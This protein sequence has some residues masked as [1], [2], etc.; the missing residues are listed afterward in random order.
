MQQSGILRCSLLIALG[1]IGIWATEDV[2]DIR[3]DAGS[4]PQR[5]A[6][7]PRGEEPFLWNNFEHIVVEK[8]SSVGKL[9]V[10]RIPDPTRRS[11]KEQAA[12]AL[13]TPQPTAQPQKRQDN[14]QVQALSQQLQSLSQ[15]AT[16]ALSS[17][18]SS[19]SSAMS[20][21]S[22]SAQSVRQSADQA[23]RSANQN[24][25]DANRQL[26]QTIS[27]ASSALSAASARASDDLGR[28]LSS[29]SS[30]LSSNLAS[31]QSSANSAISAARV[32]ASSSA[33]NA[34]NIAASQ[35]Q[36]ARADASGIRGDANSIVTQVQSNSVSGTNVAVIVTVSV[37]GTAILTAIASYFVVRCLRKKRRNRDP[38]AG[39]MN[40]NNEKQQYDTS[41]EKPIAVRG[42]VASPS[43]RFTPFGGGTGYPMDKFKLPELG[44]SPFLRKKTNEASPSLS[45]IGF[46]RS[47]Y[48]P[49][50]SSRD[51]VAGPSNSSNSDVYGV[52]PTSFRLQKENSIKSATSVRLIRVGSNKGKAQEEDETALLSPMNSPPPPLPAQVLAAP[53]PTRVPVAVAVPV[54]MQAQS[55]QQ[56]AEPPSPVESQVAEPPP[57]TI[58]VVRNSEPPEDPVPDPAPI[59]R[60]ET[61]NVMST[62]TSQQRL[63]FRDSSDVESAEPSPASGAWRRSRSATMSSMRNT[64]TAFLRTNS[65]S[66]D[67]VGS[68]SP[69][70]RPKNA[71]P[72]SFATFP[73]IRDGPPRG[74][75]AEAIMNR[76]RSGLSGVTAR[77]RDEAERRKREL[78]EVDGGRSSV[79]MSKD[80][81]EPE[82]RETRGP[83]WP[84]GST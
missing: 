81:S 51:V 16:Q 53:A 57:A 30:R 41:Y 60:S 15:S 21:V 13:T 17:V 67:S 75:A 50:D 70:R 6:Q 28:S 56:F 24:A 35:I 47:N 48:S 38:L 62:M 68:Q 2:G 82:K 80:V 29:M 39:G 63:R 18:S 54:T 71:G 74:S 33:S 22:Q 61:M 26:S 65:T 64:N 84:F 77:L 27:S 55:Q 23:V 37:V 5:V 72:A 69:P 12:P 10:E 34:I 36:A 4:S 52:S 79:R 45:D 1:T 58:R 78:D 42:T 49:R 46:A 14:G 19:A 25:D 7:V 66:P 20:L 73:R 11:P 40:S 76:G 59:K 32:E 44:L 3:G 9:I 31:A 43:P 8:D 83:N